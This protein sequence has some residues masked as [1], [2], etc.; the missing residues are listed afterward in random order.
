MDRIIKTYG[1]V[2]R[3][4]PS[5]FWPGFIVGL[6]YFSY[7]F[8]WYWP[9][10]PLTDLGVEGNAYSFVL[11]SFMFSLS[12]AG[13][14]LFWGLFSFFISR[15][16]KKSKFLLIPFI[17]A[18]TF[19]L[20]EYARAWG[21][22]FLWL[23]SGSLLGSHWT[24]G[25]PAYLLASWPF[26]LRVSSVW[27]IY[28]IDFLLVWIISIVFLLATGKYAVNSK[29]LFLNLGLIILA[30]FLTIGLSAKSNGALTP[31]MIK[32]ALIQTAD[33]TRFKFSAD[34]VLANYTKKLEM[35]KEAASVID[36]GIVIF[37]ESSNF[38]KIL[39]N[40]LDSKSAKIY[41]DRL[42]DKEFIIIDNNMLPDSESYKSRTLFINSKNGVSG[43][44]DKQL[45]TPAGEYIPYILRLLLFALGKSAPISESSGLKAGTHPELLN[46]ENLQIKI[47]AC[48]DVV[49]PSISSQDQY[50]LLI[51]LQNLSAFK[52]SGAIRSQFLSMLRFRAAENGKYA[53]LVSNFGRSYVIDSNG[54]IVKSTDSSGY[55]ILTADVVLNEER[56]WYNRL[57]DLPILLLSL[58]VF[59]YSVL[60]RLKH[61]PG[62]PPR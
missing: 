60:V 29:A 27:G 41:F 26:V 4:R 55:Q 7:L 48:S 57:G 44:Y 11:I 50:G 6:I 13:T 15:L 39:L 10:Y 28:G 25:N 52:G 62:N 38:S 33:A 47:L 17:T 36:G 46:Y 16:N 31:S 58:A 18:G 40:F 3:L 37:P 43:F 23:G 30:F 20:A 9:L 51:F 21:F 35:L 49:S 34:E 53:V 61:E 14:A 8:R 42:S 45:L 12:V 32:V 56:T 2:A 24:L 19:V 59:C 1:K 5:G 22:G 54:N